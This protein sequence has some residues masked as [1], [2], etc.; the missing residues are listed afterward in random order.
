ME[1]HIDHLKI[2][3][4]TACDVIKFIKSLMSHKAFT[5]ELLF[6]FSYMYELW[7]N[8]LREFLSQNTSFL[9][10]KESN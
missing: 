3:L 2:K 6:P 4:S 7:S 10:E 1:I 9:D 8:I 5:I